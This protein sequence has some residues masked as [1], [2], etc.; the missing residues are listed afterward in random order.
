VEAYEQ[1]A[2]EGWLSPR[3]GAATTVNHVAPTRRPTERPVAADERIVVDFR[4]GRPDIG[5]FPRERW[6]RATR[7][8]LHSMAS[9]DL[10]TSDALGFPALRRA[11][12]EYLARARGVIAD[13]DQIMVC[14]GFGQGFDLVVDVLVEDGCNRF[15]VED[16][17]YAGTC[18]QLV[19]KGVAFDGI[20][21]DHEGLV[22][23]RLRATD[24]RVVVV[25]P[26]H[27]SPT[28][29]VLGPDRRR[30]LLRWAR[31][32]DGFVIEDDYDAEYRYDRRPV[33]ALQGIAPERVIYGGTTS[34]TFASGLRLGW[35]VLPPRQVESIIARRRRLGGSP[36]AV[37][38]ATFAAFLAAGDLDRHVR[39]T[40]R[41]YRQ[42]RDA[43]IDA[44]ARWLPE[45]APSG[46]AAGLNVLLPL[47]IGTDEQDVARRALAAG[48]RV[49]P[50]A[51][52][53]L[54]T[55]ADAAP[56]LVLGYGS[57]TP[58][59]AELGIQRLAAVMT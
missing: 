51:D 16:P 1:L 33:G 15:A 12:A 19:A 49:R 45:V 31:E 11:L 14:E 26:A 18:R 29:V 27:Q 5:L 55:A 59:N 54:R 39:R 58:G 38:Q 48:V 46:I 4:P 8:A 9:G 24:A 37:L 57:V 25:T 44:V 20:G 42:R 52:F 28:G 32:I 56:G 41:V 17:G 53:R 7:T 36:S 47:P 43:V 10:A 35:F 6:A 3:R 30:Q 22:V 21:L 50:L 34:K 40:R 2:A 23:E 13:P